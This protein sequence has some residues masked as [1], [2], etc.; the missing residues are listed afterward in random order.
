MAMAAH[1]AP[2]TGWQAYHEPILGSVVRYHGPRSDQGKASQRHSTKD[3]GIGSQGR[4]IP[5]TRPAIFIAAENL[6]TRIDHI[7]EN[8][9]WATEDEIFQLDPRVEG[10][11]V[12]NFYM[13]ANRDP[14]RDKDILSD[15]TV[16]ANLRAGSDVTKVPDTGT[17]ANNRP[18][19]NAGGGVNLYRH[20]YSCWNSLVQK[21]SQ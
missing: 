12:L 6:T 19:I 4:T 10:Y 15:R 9:G 17:V 14:V 3:R 5:N 8:T 18:V 2:A 13:I 11:V 16:L 21:V 7:C 1:P 20:F